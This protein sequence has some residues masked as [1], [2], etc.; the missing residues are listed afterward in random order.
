MI[1]KSSMKSIFVELFFFKNNFILDFQWLTKQQNV[2]IIH[3]LQPVVL[4]HIFK[5]SVQKIASNI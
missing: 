5:Q 2:Y 4:I 3:V 1:R